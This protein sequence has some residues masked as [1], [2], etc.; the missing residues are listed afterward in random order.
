MACSFISFCKG[1]VWWIEK[2]SVKSGRQHYPKMIKV[3]KLDH[4]RVYL[5]A[6]TCHHLIDVTG[7]NQYVFI[8]CDKCGY[9]D[10]ADYVPKPNGYAYCPGCGAK[11]V[12]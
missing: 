12:N 7:D 9:Q 8:T 11:V 5:P 2:R 3:G 6:K 10:D 1:D 4:E